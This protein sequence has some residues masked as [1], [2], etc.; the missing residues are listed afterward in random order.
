MK[1][2][3]SQYLNECANLKNICDFYHGQHNNLLSDASTVMLDEIISSPRFTEVKKRINTGDSDINQKNL[4]CTCYSDEKLK[5]CQ[6]YHKIDSKISKEMKSKH[7]SL[8]E[9]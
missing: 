6:C 8:I 9:Q 1:R 5:N 4:N 2:F 3:C 7:N